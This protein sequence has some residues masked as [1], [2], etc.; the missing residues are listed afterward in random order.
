MLFFSRFTLRLAFYER[1]NEITTLNVLQK[2]D[3]RPVDLY[4]LDRCN[5]LHNRMQTILETGISL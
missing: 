1:K 2:H 3:L 4:S 5:N